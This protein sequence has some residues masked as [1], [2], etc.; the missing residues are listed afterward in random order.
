MFHSVSA[1]TRPSMSQLQSNAEWTPQE[2]HEDGERV[3]RCM[4]MLHI[5]SSNERC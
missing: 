3:I 4:E 5:F 1:V 2:E